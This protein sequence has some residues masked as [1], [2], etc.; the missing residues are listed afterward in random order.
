[1]SSNNNQTVTGI[2]LYSRFAL[3]GAIS[4]GV[5]HGAVT[6]VDV[7]KTLKQLYPQQYNKGMI[8]TFRQ[9]VNEKGASALLTGIGPTF[10]G[11]F[12]QGAFKFGGYEVFKEKFVNYLG[13]ERARENKNSIYVASS[14]MAEFIADIFL[15]PLEATRIRLVSQP[16]FA[17]GLVGGFARLYREEGVLKGFYSGFF[18]ILLK[19]IPYNITKFATYEIALANIL[20]IIGKQKSELSSTNETLVDLGSGLTAGIC[21]AIVSQPADTLL[22]MMNKQNASDQSISSR[23]VLLVKELGPSG[24][25]R[26]LGPRIV[27]VGAITAGQFAIYGRIKA[28]L[29]AKPNVEI[30]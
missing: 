19:Q 23:L 16:S 4:C 2:D 3:S 14:A 11:Y 13:M 1:M 18:P 25:F 24:L 8:S 29:G 30:H 26:G 6:P 22:S 15:C 28:A 12:M 7:V 10:I 20:A 17:N 5:T 9:V 21:A 27:M